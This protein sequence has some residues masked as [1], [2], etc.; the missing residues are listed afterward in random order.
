MCTIISQERFKYSVHNSRR[1]ETPGIK[2][3]SSSSFSPPLLLLFLVFSLSRFIFNLTF[4]Y[5]FIY[6]RL[7]FNYKVR[8]VSGSPGIVLHTISRDWRVRDAADERVCAPLPRRLPLHHA[9]V[10]RVLVEALVFR[11]AVTAFLLRL[12]FLAASR[13]R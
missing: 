11:C 13:L 6:I 10:I 4:I 2:V 12:V 1:R 3:A 7:R 8:Y 9:R 5:I